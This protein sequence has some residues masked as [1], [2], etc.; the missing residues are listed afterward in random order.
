M[1]SWP[2]TKKTRNQI[3]YDTKQEQDDKY[4]GEL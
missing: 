1:A 4:N 2:E 3:G